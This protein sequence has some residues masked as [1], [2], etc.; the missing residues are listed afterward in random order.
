V[1]KILIIGGGFTGLTAAKKLSDE[2]LD[3]TIVEKSEKLGGLAASFN[4]RGESLEKAYHHIFR[5]D[6]DII[7]FIE[8]LGIG[9][10]IEWHESSVGILRNGKIWPFMTPLDLLKFEPVNLLGR[11]RI[12]LAAL[13]IKRSRNVRDFKREICYVS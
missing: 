11:I 10:L 8:E 7:D 12:G 6:I 1:K 5:T 13:K 9:D 2:G 4:I 3:V